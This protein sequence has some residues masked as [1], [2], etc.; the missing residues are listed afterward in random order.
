[1]SN[2]PRR[3]IRVGDSV[4]SAAV[5][6]LCPTAPAFFPDAA[7]DAHQAEHLKDAAPQS[8]SHRRFS[9]GR[10]RGARSSNHLGAA[11]AIYKN[12]INNHSGRGRK[13]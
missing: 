4:V 10:P 3:T 6:E 8:Q 2:H 5:C 9:P 7:F 1:M 12:G 11:A 13:L